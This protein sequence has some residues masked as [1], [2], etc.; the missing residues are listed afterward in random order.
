MT[1]ASLIPSLVAAATTA[2]TLAWQLF[3]PPHQEKAPTEQEYVALQ[4]S[5][6]RQMFAGS[7]LLSSRIVFSDDVGEQDRGML[8]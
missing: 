3:F 2:G 7:S 5:S 1:Q 8:E 4:E 6:T